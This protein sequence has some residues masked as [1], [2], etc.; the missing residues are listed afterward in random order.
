MPHLHSC[1]QVASSLTQGK[2]QNHRH[3]LPGDRLSSHCL[4]D[5][6]CYHFFL[7]SRCSSRNCLLAVP[8][9]TQVIS[10]LKAFH[11]AFPSTCNS[12]PPDSCLAL[13]LKPFSLYSNV[14][15]RKKASLT[16]CGPPSPSPPC[17]FHLSLAHQQT[18]Y[19]HLFVHGL[20]LLLERKLHEGCCITENPA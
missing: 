20:C 2:S 8:P 3:G 10:C 19:T 11:L 4:S 12:V 9:R 17:V 6:M 16:T 15:S 1:C 5:L 13:L 7:R 14:L 18:C